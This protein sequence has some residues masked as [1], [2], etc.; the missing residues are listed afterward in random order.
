[1][2]KSINAHPRLK[3]LGGTVPDPEAP[4][5]FIPCLFALV[6]GVPTENKMDLL[7]SVLC[8]FGESFFLLKYNGVLNMDELSPK[9]KAEVSYLLVV[10][11]Y[12]P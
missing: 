10:L 8:L 2:L 7:N 3:F 9:E 6:R 5:K 1:M 4:D 11:Y 12:L